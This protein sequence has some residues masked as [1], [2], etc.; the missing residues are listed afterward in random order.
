MK[1]ITIWECKDGTRFSTKEDA[2]RYERLMDRCDAVNDIIGRKEELDY[3][4]WVQRNPED[5]RRA[6]RRFCGLVA[7][8]DPEHSDWAMECADGRRHRSWMATVVDNC[9][10]MCLKY[11]H[12]RFE[13]ISEDGREY[14]Q[15]FYALHP[16]K[17]GREVKIK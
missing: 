15:A 3:G 5:V 8:S 1:E 2:A 9:G 12:Y 11:L 4:E 13:C 14:D 16:E 17:A 10:L 6:W 7:E